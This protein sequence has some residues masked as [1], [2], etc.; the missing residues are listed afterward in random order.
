M[1]E[2]TREERIDEERNLEEKEQDE[3][4]EIDEQPGLDLSKD[5]DAEG[6]DVEKYTNLILDYRHAVEKLDHLIN[7]LKSSISDED[8]ADVEN[9]I[10]DA[11]NEA[12]AAKKRVDDYMVKFGDATPPNEETRESIEEQFE[13]AM[14]DTEEIAKKKGG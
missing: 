6:A 2:G 1:G 9:Q 5:Q 7:T 8:K 11:R 12:L 14:T 3:R 10:I 4:D 13:R